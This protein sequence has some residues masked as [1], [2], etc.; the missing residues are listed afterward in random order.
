LNIA[1]GHPTSEHTVLFKWLAPLA[2][3]A[4]REK[5]NELPR[6]EALAA[7]ERLNVQQ[8]INNIILRVPEL[9]KLRYE[10][11][12]EPTQG[13]EPRLPKSI[14]IH[15]WLYHVGEGLLEDLK[16]SQT[17]SILNEKDTSAGAE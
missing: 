3:V 2:A 15:G 11:I 10:N 9:L 12:E 8:Q 14:A 6:P 5:I 1:R 16:I 17:V 7:L 4:I 13:S